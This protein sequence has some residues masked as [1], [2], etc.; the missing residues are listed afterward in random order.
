MKPESAP[1]STHPLT[2]PSLGKVG[3][4]TTFYVKSRSG[5]KSY[6]KKKRIRV[7]NDYVRYISCILCWT[8]SSLKRLVS[9][10]YTLFISN[11]PHRVPVGTGVLCRRKWCLGVLLKMSWSQEKRCSRFIFSVGAF[12][13]RVFFLLVTRMSVSCNNWHC[14]S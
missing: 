3:N 7:E 8:E 12:F 10:T 1:S 2:L 4:K 14:V 9:H 5:N 11:P 6:Q 13:P